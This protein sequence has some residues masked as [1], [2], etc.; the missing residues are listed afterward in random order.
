MSA[1]GTRTRSKKSSPPKQAPSVDPR[2]R[3]RRIEVKR[4]QGR[5]RLRTLVALVIVTVV[6]GGGVVASQSSL[7]DVDAVIVEGSTRTDPATVVQASGIGL[8]QPLVEVDVE[9]AA[10]GVAQLPWV[11]DVSVD[12]RLSGEVVVEIQE[13]SPI[14]AL[15]TSDGG[16][17]VVD[18]GGR[19]LERVPVLPPEFVPIAG[20]VASGEIGQPSPPET[21]SALDLIEQL[22]DGLRPSVSQ[23]V[24][25]QG[26]LFVV[27]SGGGRVNFGDAS[28]LD[29]KVVSLETMLAHADLRCLF[30][31]DVRVPSA[32]ALTRVNAAGVPRATLTD[33]SL[34]T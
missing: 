33:L 28:S 19:Q 12:R 11:L 8:G 30:E 5:R 31:I 32:P 23:I 22:T 3:A 24:V 7:L 1:S 34:C 20:I 10:A 18:Q 29:D 2:L 21:Q 6:L 16:L 27:L 15:P 9:G 26:S 25:D 17:V 13:R 4:D 14:A